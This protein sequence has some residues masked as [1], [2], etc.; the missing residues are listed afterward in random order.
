M[1]AASYSVLVRQVISILNAQVAGTAYPVSDTD[2]TAGRR[3]IGEIK[4]AIIEADLET[5]VAICETLGNGFRVNFVAPTAALTPLSGN[6]QA[7]ELPER[8]GPVSNVEIQIA[9]GDTTWV[10][11]EQS[12]LSEIREIVRNPDTVFQVAHNVANSPTG[13]FYFIDEASD[14]IHFTGNA[15]RVYVATIGTIDRT[16]PALLTPDA[17]SPFIVARAVQRCWKIGDPGE[18]QSHYGNLAEQFM[19]LIR[20]GAPV[21][22]HVEPVITARAA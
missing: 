8:I 12:P 10:A 3:N 22:P 6:A 11:G 15:V 5:R 18:L 2:V 19:G 4:E 20:Q 21:L 17:Y 16:T 7:A 1:A 9:S 14:V 13:G